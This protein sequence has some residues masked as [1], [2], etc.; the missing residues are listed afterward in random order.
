M[1]LERQHAC[2]DNLRFIYTAIYTTASGGALLTVTGGREN[3][4]GRAKKQPERRIF[5][6]PVTAILPYLHTSGTIPCTCCK[7]CLCM[8]CS[9]GKVQIY[10]HV[11][12]A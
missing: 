9:A 11:V 8:T 2:A 4:N 12:N 3:S 10:L 5:L 6:P 7:P 1:E